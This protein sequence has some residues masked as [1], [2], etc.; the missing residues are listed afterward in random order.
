ML[1]SAMIHF[2]NC[3]QWN[4]I[5][6]IRQII[7]TSQT[8]LGY[9]L[10]YEMFMAR[11][12][13]ARPKWLLFVEPV[14]IRCATSVTC[15]ASFHVKVFLLA[16]V[17]RKLKNT[18]KM[19]ILDLGNLCTSR[20]PSRFISQKNKIWMDW[21]PVKRVCLMAIQCCYRSSHRRCSI[22]LQLY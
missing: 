17:F 8:T 2:S 4:V 19:A 5:S 15:W 18:P 11:I 9:I 3:S 1:M 16:D 21:K 14:W 22:G 7:C 13:W 10:G 6:V 20:T 12:L